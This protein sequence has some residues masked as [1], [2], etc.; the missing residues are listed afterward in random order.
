MRQIGNTRPAPGPKLEVYQLA[1]LAHYEAQHLG[2][3]L[4]ADIYYRFGFDSKSVPYVDPSAPMAK[5][6]ATT[7]LGGPLPETVATPGYF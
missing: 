6:T 5:L 2:F 7:I 3:L 4:M 1:D